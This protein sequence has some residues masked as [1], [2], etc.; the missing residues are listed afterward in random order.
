MD[1]FVE[2]LLLLLAALLVGAIVYAI[3]AESWRMLHH[4]GR[5]RLRRML[6]RHGAS[7][8]AA[9]TLG[10]ATYETARAT[11]RCVACASK[12]QCDAWLASRKRDGIEA[13]CPNAGFIAHSAHR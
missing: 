8:N 4:D 13:F 6:A 2:I 5:L 9:A 10:F 7:L 3:F 1:L 12:A 11:R